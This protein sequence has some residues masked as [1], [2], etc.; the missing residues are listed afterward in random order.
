MPARGT[1]A[2][3][4]PVPNDF[5]EVFIRVGWTSIEAETQAHAKTIAKWLALRNA[6]RAA[7]RLPT[8]QDAR[9]AYVRAHG[10]ALS[11]TKIAEAKP[12]SNAARYVLGRRRRPS[13]PCRAPKFWDFGLLPG[14]AS[15]PAPERPRRVVMTPDRAAAIV[16]AA[17]KEMEA[18]PEFVAGMVRAAELLREQGRLV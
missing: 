4:R 15:Q 7:M 3:Y 13:W 16:E 11:A 9:A 10:P 2:L 18:G 6:E 5:D 1:T 17:A 14:V 8:L 12:R